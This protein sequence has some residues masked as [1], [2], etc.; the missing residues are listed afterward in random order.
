MIRL[1]FEPFLAL[2]ESDEFRTAASFALALW[3]VWLPL[4]AVLVFFQGW[5]N[6]IR[7]KWATEQTGILLELKL[8]TEITRSPAAMEIVLASLAQSGVG[9]Y[10]D[11]YLKGRQK[12][13]FSLELASLGGQVKFFIWTHKKFKDIIEAQIY[14]QF[15]TVEV[16]EVPDYALATPFDLNAINLWAMQL[17]LTKADPFP[18]KT[19]IDYGLDKDPKEEYKIDP[20]TPLLEFLGSV[21]PG[22]QVWI[23]ILICAHTKEHYKHGRLHEKPD[24]KAGAKKA[25]EDVMKESPVKPEEGKSVPLSNLTEIQKETINAIQR[26]LVK[27]PFDTAIRGIYV[28]GK[29]VYNP[30]YIG[31]LTGSFKQFGSGNLNGFKPG[32]TT[33][34]DY[35]WQ[36]YKGR[37]DAGNK[38]KLFDAYRKRSYFYYPYKHLKTK[39]F[40][41]TTEEL[42]TIF[43][44]PGKVASTPTLDRMK[45]RKAE[46]P[47]NLPI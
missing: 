15:P 12:P 26:N 16:Y 23:Q 37:R 21:K 29:D 24:W 30:I 11:V 42:A 28:A 34:F 43:H 4:I 45:S 27:T 46:P 47:A 35:P 8:P 6:Y 19:Y 20:M 36:D 38:K 40:V 41:L 18:I 3:P 9:T 2:L 14:A 13:W 33:G 22:H 25:I 7:A 32:F 31:G 17:E 39:P 10:L 1:M 44:F 5:F